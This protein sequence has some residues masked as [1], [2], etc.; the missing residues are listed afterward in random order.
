MTI[1]TT[2]PGTNIRSRGER[3]EPALLKSKIRRGTSSSHVRIRIIL[4]Q[5]LHQIPFCVKINRLDNGFDLL[6]RFFTC[7][8]TFFFC[9]SLLFL[10]KTSFLFFFCLPLSLDLFPVRNSL[11]QPISL[12][13]LCICFHFFFSLLLVFFASLGSHSFFTSSTPRIIV[14]PNLL[15]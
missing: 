1:F 13:L 5:L 8:F 10:L 11:G 4:F 7:S 9:F 12:L 14:V 3:H 6:L 2:E 15:P